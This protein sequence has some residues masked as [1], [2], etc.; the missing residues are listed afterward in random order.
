MPD[1]FIR[2]SYV[3]LICL[4]LI[5]E[6]SFAKTPDWQTH[7]ELTHAP[8]ASHTCH[9]L[10]CPRSAD[11]ELALE[12]EFWR[13]VQQEDGDGISRWLDKVVPYTSHWSHRNEYLQQK[14]RLWMLVAAAHTMLFN[15][16]DMH[17]LVPIFNDLKSARV[18][19]VLGGLSQGFEELP[20]LYHLAEAIRWSIKANQQIG[21]HQNAQTFLLGIGGFAQAVLPP[22]YGITGPDAAMNTLY[23]SSC[24]D[25]PNWL[26][27]AFG[28][29]CFERGLIGPGQLAYL[30]CI[31]EQSCLSVGAGTEGLFVGALMKMLMHDRHYIASALAMLGDGPSADELAL[32]DNFWCE[33]NSPNEPTASLPEATSIA[34]FKR[35]GG[36]MAI[37]EGYAKLEE[38]EKM[39]LVLKEARSEAERLAW[40]FMDL[41]EEHAISLRGG[42]AKRGIPNLVERWN[43]PDPRRDL[44]GKIQLPLPVSGGPRA[45]AACHFGGVLNQD[46]SY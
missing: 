38:F 42:D 24:Q 25:M 8:I 36:L 44:I 32:C 12:K 17:A 41:L 33:F 28:D 10:H 37:A 11:Y 46:V 4:F 45:C 22:I 21:D 14:G 5:A 23:G 40:P 18:I 20:A 29:T 13:H 19:D 35:I 1:F 6:P 26:I 3:T 7:S 34:P 31:D 9:L 16:Y 39:E 15:Q 2:S 30:D 43:N 27:Q